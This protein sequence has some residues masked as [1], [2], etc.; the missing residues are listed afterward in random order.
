[1]KALL[2]AFGVLALMGVGVVFV[3]GVSPN[4][5]V[6]PEHVFTLGG[7]QITNT[8]FSSWWV[9]LFLCIVAFVTRRGLKLVPSG[10][11]A[12]VE[13]AVVAFLGM[14]EQVAGEKNG[15]RFFPLVATIFFFI[16]ASNYFGL[17]PIN[18]II[19]KPELAHG[20]KQVV[21]SQTS[22]PVIGDLAYIPLNPQTINVGAGEQ[23]LVP[24]PT[25]MVCG[26][27]GM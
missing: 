27:S 3:G 15:R 19:G 12:Y 18:N 26:L 9:V 2:I 10:F 20:A 22:L 21:F 14:V 1:M 13:A 5:V 23:P 17:L 4:I 8:M 6:A 24:A 11:A 25:L 16:L 7:V